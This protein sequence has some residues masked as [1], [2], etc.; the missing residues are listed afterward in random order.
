MG[1]F[2]LFICL[3]LSYCADLNCFE[4]YTILIAKV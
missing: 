4:K 2:K 3:K 1:I